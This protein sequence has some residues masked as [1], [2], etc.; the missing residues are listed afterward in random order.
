MTCQIM[1][2]HA[3]TWN[4]P[5]EGSQITA[6]Y[7][8]TTE[9]IVDDGISCTVGIY[10]PVGESEPCIYGLSVISILE[11]PKDSADLKKEKV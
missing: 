5:L 3:F 7:K 1:N 9:E 6:D 4:G 10:K 8:L 11:T 2:L